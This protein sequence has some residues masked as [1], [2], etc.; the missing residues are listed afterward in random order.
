MVKIFNEVSKRQKNFWNNCLFHPTDAV[1]DDWG[2]RILDQM[3]EDKAIQTVRIY[4]MFEDIVSLDE[5]GDLRFDYT[6]SDTRMDYLLEKGYDLLLAYGGMPDCIARELNGKQS[7][8]KNK[9]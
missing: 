3:A 5:N 8:S 9:R 6:L 4:T 7:N 1:E 2:R